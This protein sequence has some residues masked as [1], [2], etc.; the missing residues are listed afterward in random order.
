LLAIAASGFLIA[1][2]YG[3]EKMNFKV[4]VLSEMGKNMLLL[5]IIAF[6]FDQYV[7]FLV[8]GYRDFLIANPILTMILVG[9]LPIIIE[10][11]IAMLLARKNIVVKI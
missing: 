2:F 4:P 7:G 8:D 3:F 10:A 6:I 9:V 5:F 1:V 11:G